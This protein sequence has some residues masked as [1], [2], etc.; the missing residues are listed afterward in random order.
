MGEFGNLL[1]VSALMY[2]AL[3]VMQALVPGPLR[4]TMRVL[5]RLGGRLWN[6][7][8]RIPAARRGRAFGLLWLGCTVW[9]LSLVGVL[10]QR[11][12]GLPGLIV[13]GL[14]LVV[15]RI[16]LA[17]WQRRAAAR[18]QRPLPQREDW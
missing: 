17:W 12:H 2:G 4:L 11:G 15:Y 6:V 18:I 1:I 14:L 3:W 9:L 10:G 7:A 13:F 5:R 8:Y 16:L